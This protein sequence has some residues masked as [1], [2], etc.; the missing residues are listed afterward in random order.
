M[1][2]P[3]KVWIV[4]IIVFIAVLPGQSKAEILGSTNIR[5]LGLQ[6]D[7][8]T[9]PDIDGLQT[10]MTAVKDIPTG[11]QAFV[12]VP[13]AAALPTLAPGSLVKAEMSGPALG[14]EV[15]TL[16]GVPNQLMEIPP[17]GAAGDYRLFNVRLEGPDGV[18]ILRRTP[19]LDSIVINV[20]DELLVSQ[21]TSRPL[22]LDEIQEKGIV[23]DEDNFTAFNFAIGLTLGSEQVV[24]DLPVAIP[25]TNQAAINLDAPSF[26]S[27]PPV[28]SQFIAS[29]FAS[30][31]AASISWT[32]CPCGGRRTATAS[33]APTSTTGI[34]VRSACS[35]W[36]ASTGRPGTGRF[37]TC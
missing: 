29:R 30:S 9:R 26:A 37:A 23:I 10:T 25:N 28:R 15:V 12:G 2:C 20:I 31:A 19:A 17:L 35:R 18:V 16:V 1:N 11:V 22:T 4:A 3:V 14:N 13:G 24:I 6:V 34:T 8:D 33:R 5:V 32:T 21:V 36:A 27:L 7:L